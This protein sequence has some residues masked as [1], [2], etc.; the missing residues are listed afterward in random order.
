MKKPNILIFLTDDHAQWANG[1]YGNSC[2]N[3]PSI[4]Y[5]ASSGVKFENAFTPNPVCSP[6][7]ASF[8]TG[9]I[10]SR[11]G[12]HDHINVPEHPGIDGQTNLGEMLKG[13]GYHTGFFGKWHCHAHGSKPQPGFDTWFS[14]WFGTYALFSDQPFSDN[15]K[16]V[17]YYG[18][19]APIISDATVKFLDAH[20]QSETEEP[21]FIYVGLTD[22]HGPHALLPERLVEKYRKT[23]LESVEQETF[24]DAHGRARTPIAEDEN[25]RR[26]ELAQYYAAAEL[27]DEQVGRIIDNLQSAGELE[28]TV[29]I[30]TSDHGT[31]NGQHGL[32]GKGNATIPQN[33]I[34]ESIM[35]PLLVR[36]PDAKLHG[37]VVNCQVDHC[38][39]HTTIKEIA[40]LEP[41]PTSPGKSWLPLLSQPEDQSDISWRKYQFCEYGNV[42][43]IRTEEG[44]KLIKRYPGPNGHF[45]DE[46]YNLQKDPRECSNVI[47]DPQY[48]AVIKELS[49]EL[50]SYFSKYE[51]E[52]WSGT[53]LSTQ[54]PLN[55]C[56]LWRMSL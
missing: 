39:L 24:S 53:T 49:Q 33:L 1:C 13:A 56:E 21:Y 19:Q 41:T 31:M 2:V 16:R 35:V 18:H 25:G 48:S 28:N 20:R 23:C 11:H 29:I 5:L 26:E 46:F 15:G 6:S 42:R 36:H 40:G 52:K 37:A 45:E 34:E 12:I 38:D 50:D 54:R 51:D 9:S 43:M 47:S 32:S 17:E 22:T 4:D 55:D 8:W 10:P 27:V 7:R 30:Y 44:L 3:T 14:Q